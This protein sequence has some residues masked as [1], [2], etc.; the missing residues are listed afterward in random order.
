MN[1]DYLK[2][3]AIIAPVFLV[4][5]CGFVMRRAGKLQPQA[6]STLFTIAINFLYPCLIMHKVL[7]NSDLRDPGK[8]LLA[9]VVGAALLLGCFAVAVLAARVLRLQRP[10]PAATFAFT[11]GLPNWGYVPIPIMLALFGEKTVGVLFVHNIGLELV[12]W[13][14]GVQLLTGAGSWRR[15]L[16][17]PFFA[18]LGAIVLNLAHAGDWL[19]DFVLATLKFLGDAALPLSVLLTG[20]SL[21][22]A[23]AEGGLTK[24]ARVSI[25][26]CVVRLAILPVLILLATK[27]LSLWG[28]FP[29]ELKQVL[30]V[31]AAM[32][33][34]LLPVILARHY[35]DSGGADS[36]TAVRVVLATTL[37]GLVTIPLWLRV[38]AWWL[39][40]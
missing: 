26:G 37:V 2:L 5:A 9:P 40:V 8:V 39:G 28:G 17:V 1:T 23:V 7:G 24:D 11:A 18:V 29:R 3:L 30:I 10:Q 32:P 34:A 16:N 6:D 14:V 38:G 22:D 12:L 4:V 20:V 13:S 35:R 33:S 19:P 27:G 36:G 15:A 21:A 25:A 31:Q